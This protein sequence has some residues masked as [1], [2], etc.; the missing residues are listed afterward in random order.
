MEEIIKNYKE[1]FGWEPIVENADR[2]KEYDNFVVCG[3]GTAAFAADF[4][5]TGKTGSKITVWKDYGLPEIPP[6]TLV[7]V[8]SYS[9][10]TEE[11][12]D[13]FAE[14]RQ[15]RLPMAVIT[16]SGQMLIDAKQHSIPFIQ[17]PD[18]GHAM[19]SG[20]SIKS[21]MKLM[22]S[23]QADTMKEFAALGDLIDIE[24]ARIEG[25]TLANSLKE[26]IPVVC[27]SNRNYPLA[28]NWKVKL[29]ERARIPAFA[30]HFPEMNH[31][32]MTGL[33]SVPKNKSLSEGLYFV[34]LQ[35]ETDD[36]R[37]QKRMKICEA[38][39]KEREFGTYTVEMKG[40]SFLHK[41]FQNI[42]VANWTVF[43]LAQHY[44]SLT[45]GK[46]GGEFEKR[47]KEKPGFPH[48]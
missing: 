33:D 3:V 9:G 30:N 31:N 26:K 23:K 7:I 45:E 32:E 21:L 15:K 12:I 25:E 28:Y 38:L 35:D 4:L 44:G 46:I 14:A 48:S 2:L 20:Y 13:S 39:Y 47:I 8:C 42:F 22:G 34:F 27:A 17:L 36:P 18:T 16:K 40:K 5:S 43:Y 6:N 19:M 29:N 1:Q 10:T 41:I 11:A 37:I 24:E